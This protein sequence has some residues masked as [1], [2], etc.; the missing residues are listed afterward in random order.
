MTKLIRKELWEV[1]WVFAAGFGAFLVAVEACLWHSS[2]ALPTVLALAAAFGALLASQQFAGEVEA[3]TFELLLARPVSRRA[4]WGA[5]WLTS[6]GLTALGASYTVFLANGPFRF[7]GWSALAG[8]GSLWTLVTFALLGNAVGAFVSTQ[9]SKRLDAVFGSVFAALIT[10]ASICRSELDWTAPA[11]A[12]AAVLALASLAAVE[13]GHAMRCWRRN[14]AGL[15]VVGAGSVALWGGVYALH[16]FETRV[17]APLPARITDV[18]RGD[19]GTLLVTVEAATGPT[20]LFR[21]PDT[22]IGCVGA[23]TG[24]I[25]WLPLRW[26]SA[27]S[28]P[29]GGFAT[30]LGPESFGGYPISASLPGRLELRTGQVAYNSTSSGEA[31]VRQG[32]RLVEAASGGGLGER[33]ELHR[34][35]PSGD[36][37]AVFFSRPGLRIVNFWCVESAVVLLGRGEAPG[38]ACTALAL[39]PDGRVLEEVRLLTEGNRS[40]EMQL[41][42]STISRGPFGP[43]GG[44]AASLS[45]WLKFWNPLEH[46]EMH[47]LLQFENGRFVVCRLVGWFLP[48]SLQTDCGAGE[49][50]MSVVEPQG[51]GDW[52]GAL[53][54]LSR[55][56]RQLGR[57]ELGR[58]VRVAELDA[59][60]DGRRAIVR[61]EAG[62]RTQPAYRLM[63]VGTMLAMPILNDVQVP[64]R[65]GHTF[66]WLDSTRWFYVLE[67]SIRLVDETRPGRPVDRVV[68]RF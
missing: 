34:A 21:R 26:V 50:L 63:D 8:D 25:D 31:P 17:K 51:E 15:A 35:K 54:R 42:R 44:E 12:L 64:F 65:A 33:W 38:G 6:A 52:S 22:R 47:E 68:F 11:L 41:M 20:N 29:E 13:R 67:R 39:G 9:V 16:L 24:K 10:T 19:A 5:K 36:A 32:F 66:G 58:H 37:G 57:L 14:A 49:T 48:G 56:G 23:A 62:E 45:C 1:F 27:P 60:P 61:L 40:I 55:Q 43:G 4:I 18:V 53:L 3:G 2:H 59:S 28:A 30:I 46:R 7:L